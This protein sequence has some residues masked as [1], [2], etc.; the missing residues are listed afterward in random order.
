VLKLTWQEGIFVLYRV[1]GSLPVLRWPFAGAIIAMLVDLC[2]LFLMDWLGGIRNYQA[3][4]KW[5]DQV[6]LAAFLVVALRWPRPQRTV[7]AGLYAYRLVG[8]GLFELTQSR[9]VLVLFPNLFEF[10]FV[11]VASLKHWRKDYAFN[12]R[13][14]LLALVPLLLLKESQELVLH[15]FKLLDGFT[16]VEAVKTVWEFA[17]SWFQAAGPGPVNRSSGPW[18]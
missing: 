9:A 6:Y 14:I 7:A 5:C 3:L 8:F 12:N 11:F 2:D 10:W 4:D 16:A 17:L 1:L 18:P 13:S 15:W